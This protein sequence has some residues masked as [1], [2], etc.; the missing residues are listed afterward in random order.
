MKILL[1]LALLVSPHLL[2]GQEALSDQ[3]ATDTMQP[4]R[5][6]P[7]PL[8][9]TSVAEFRTRVHKSRTQE[10]RAAR[11]RV[12]ALEALVSF[13]GTGEGGERASALMATAISEADRAMVELNELQRWMVEK[14]GG[15]T[16]CALAIP[17]A[18]WNCSP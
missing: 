11:L 8:D 16:D 14:A 12:A 6:Q 10:L 9:E 3:P 15:R 18:E 5:D 1:L 7:A 2:R 13:L 4:T 17:G